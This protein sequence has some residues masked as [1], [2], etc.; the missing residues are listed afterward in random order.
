MKTNA[1]RLLALLAASLPA[2]G[3]T[4]TIIRE[5]SGAVLGAKG[6]Y[7]QIQPLAP[8]KETK[9]LGAYSRFELGTIADGIGGRTPPDFIAHLEKA[10]PEEVRGARLPD[11]DTGKTLVIRGAIAHYES[12]STIG[13]VLGPMEEVIC[14]TEL[15]DKD[16]GRVL[17]VANCIGRTN[18][19]SNAGVKSKASGLAKAFVKWIESG[20]PA[21]MKTKAK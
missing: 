2:A 19:A 6:T 18:A 9:T 1:I 12:A 21:D 20:F 11:G 7:M 4:G 17:G 16:S 8:D 10:F 14:R 13:Y 15:V 3:C 5:A